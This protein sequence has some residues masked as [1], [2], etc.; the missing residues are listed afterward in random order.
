MYHGGLMQNYWAYACR[1]WF[2]GCV[3]GDQCTIINPIGDL[4]AQSTNYYPYVTADIN[5]D[6]RVAHFDYNRE[7]FQAAKQ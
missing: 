4:V 3:P 7:K 5:L 2:I 1:S 6:Y